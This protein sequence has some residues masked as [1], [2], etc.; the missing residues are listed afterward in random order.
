MH[1]GAGTCFE[2]TKPVS[3][4]FSDIDTIKV[5]AND[6]I[7]DNNIIDAEHTLNNQTKCPKKKKQHYSQVCGFSFKNVF[8]S[9]SYFIYSNNTE[10]KLIF[11]NSNTTS[12]L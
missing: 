3:V 8:C 2:I 6:N 7:I 9:C 4:E 5:L 11:R 12:L 10:L 1:F